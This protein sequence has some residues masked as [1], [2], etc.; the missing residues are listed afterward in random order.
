GVERYGSGE[1]KQRPAGHVDGLLD[2]RLQREKIF[3]VFGPMRFLAQLLSLE[4]LLLGSGAPTFF[5]L[6]TTL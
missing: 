6:P 4:L 2:N 5:L 3:I 1:S